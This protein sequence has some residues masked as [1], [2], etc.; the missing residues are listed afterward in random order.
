MEMSVLSNDVVIADL[1]R[2]IAEIVEKPELE[3]L[4]DMEQSIMD[5]GVDSLRII[6]LIVLVEGRYNI[7]FEDEELVLENFSDLQSMVDKVFLKLGYSA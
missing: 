6:Q 5:V 4:L 2:M 7:A 3:Y 1:K